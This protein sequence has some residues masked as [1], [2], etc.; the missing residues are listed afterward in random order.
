[1]ELD[2]FSNLSSTIRTMAKT[3]LGGQ[4][5]FLLKAVNVL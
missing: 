5:D 1:M 2:A 3:E 4:A